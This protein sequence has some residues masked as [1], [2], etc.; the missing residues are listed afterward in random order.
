M[1]IFTS[2]SRVLH[3]SYSEAG[4][5]KHDKMGVVGKTARKTGVAD[6]TAG[7]EHLF[8]LG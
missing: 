6:G 2:V 1:L 8:C 3:R 4:L 5:K 7:F